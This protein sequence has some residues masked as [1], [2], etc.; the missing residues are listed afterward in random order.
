MN[1][2]FGSVLY[3]GLIALI[4]R[5]TGVE[6]VLFPELGALSHDILK[7]PQGT[8]ARSPVMLVATP[9]ATALVG[10]LITRH[11]A[12][13]AF[14]VL[15]DIAASVLMIFVSRSPIAPAISA[16]LL[17]LTMGYRSWWYPPSIVLGTGLLAIVS[18]VVRRRAARLPVPPDAV[19]D[20]VDDTMEVAPFYLGWVSPFLVLLVLLAGIAQWTGMRFVLFPP[21]VVIA[22][23]MFA[24]PAVCPWARRAWHLPLACTASAALGVLL[25]ALFGAGI[26]GTM[27][28][29]LG[30]VLILRA[31]DLHAPP[32]LAVG[33][34]PMIIPHPDYRFV[35][36][37]LTGTVMLVGVF[38]CW[39]RIA[40]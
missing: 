11:L 16:G 35:L 39:R 10:T 38:A 12:Y 22:F 5:L 40:A 30:S 19:R 21:L 4:A 6:F 9:V 24:H 33:L 26:A 28:S 14:P 13:G 8:W 34:L 32:A 17:P 7:R 37:V 1:L 29:M 31:L 18:V 27:L 2:E 25:V 20:R 23:E 15:L 36:A 3:M